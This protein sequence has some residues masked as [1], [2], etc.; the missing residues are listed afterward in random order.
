M[1]VESLETIYINH[2]QGICC[3]G[4]LVRV[5]QRNRTNKLEIYFKDLA[6]VIVEAPATTKSDGGGQ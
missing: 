1:E 6:T 3:N 2:Q 5:H 4:I